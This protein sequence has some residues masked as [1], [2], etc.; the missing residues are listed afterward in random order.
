MLSV[1]W[2]IPPENEQE[3]VDGIIKPVFGKWQLTVLTVEM[4]YFPSCRCNVRINE[5]A[6]VNVQFIR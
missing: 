5:Y 1:K 4:V 3:K 6:I 2:L